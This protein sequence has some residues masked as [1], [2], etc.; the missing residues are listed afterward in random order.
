MR[1][2]FNRK[3]RYMF[4]DQDL[5]D[6]LED[7]VE[8]NNKLHPNGKLNLKL[9]V[10]VFLVDLITIKQGL[11][12]SKTNKGFAKICAKILK[13]YHHNYN[14]HIDFLLKNRVLKRKPYDAKKGKCFAYKLVWKPPFKKKWAQRKMKAYTPQDFTFAKRIN[15]DELKAKDFANGRC[16]HLTKWLDSDI[17]IAYED[18]LQYLDH[19]E[20][21]GNQKYQRRHAIERI[22]QG[23]WVYSRNGKD[24]RLHSN[25]V[26]LP[27]D[28][29]Q[30]I[31]YKGQI[32][33]SLD[34]KSSQPFILAGIL[35]LCVNGSYDL[36]DSLIEMISDRK[37]AES[38]SS[39]LAVMIPKISE[40]PMN[41]DI[42]AFI[43]LVVTGDIYN[44]LGQ[45]YSI[46]FLSTITTKNGTIVDRFFDESIDKKVDKQFDDLRGYSK[47]VMLEYL[48]CSPKSNEKRLNE[49][50]R[51]LPDCINKFVDLMK[52]EN[53]ADFPILLQNIEAALFLDTLTKELSEKYQDMF[54]ATIH[55]SIV[56]PIN[57]QTEVHEFMRKRTFEIFEIVPEVKYEIWGKNISLVA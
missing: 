29:R 7:K 55:D 35:N 50:R 34:F 52:G 41:T 33:C 14:T 36:L 8:W 51:I 47:V 15:N 9:D 23:Y 39:T 45:Q 44:Y 46:E 13:Q 56:V 53:K 28:L 49:V 37:L 11:E 48:Y 40:T 27:S 3:R 31:T 24:D 1:A 25:L 54:M 38:L 26:N 20:M 6:Y 57:Y 32:L 17:N 10:V 2:V 21:N 30:F 43:N 12:R 19:E 16:R 5:F 22:H 4:L 42:R 18:S